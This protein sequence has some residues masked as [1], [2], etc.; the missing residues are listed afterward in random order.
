MTQ[1]P[2]SLL[3]S[4][5]S[6]E[7]LCRVSA[8]P[9]SDCLEQ[10]VCCTFEYL[11]HWWCYL[12][13]MFTSWFLCRLLE[14]VNLNCSLR[15]E[16]LFHHIIL[17]EH[18]SKIC[19]KPTFG[20]SEA[21][22]ETS[23]DY[24]ESPCLASEWADDFLSSLWPLSRCFKFQAS[25]IHEVLPVSSAAR[26]V[27]QVINDSLSSYWG[28]AAARPLTFDLFFN[29]RSRT[30]IHLKMLYERMESLKWRRFTVSNNTS[31]ICFKKNVQNKTSLEILI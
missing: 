8:Q 22:S 26:F 16:F 5:T 25:V 6:R 17:I 3:N 29:N 15:S 28:S 19:S 31:E 11:A 12:Q 14:D 1:W 20:V 9:E 10:R 4:S 13:L 2:S 18:E 7:N 27:K 21:K 30:R 24:P 23:Q